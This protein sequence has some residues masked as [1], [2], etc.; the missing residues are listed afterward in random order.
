MYDFQSE[1]SFW[2]NTTVHH[3]L[4]SHQLDQSQWQ[5]YLLF[6]LKNN[7]SYIWMLVNCFIFE[8]LQMNV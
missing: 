5:D 7:L 1:M 2:S 8:K 6:L 3:A 4:L